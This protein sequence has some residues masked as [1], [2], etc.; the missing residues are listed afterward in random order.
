MTKDEKL[1]T[2]IEGVRFRYSPDASTLGNLIQEL[3]QGQEAV[4]VNGPWV[5]VRVGAQEGWIHADYL[6]EQVPALAFKVGVPNLTG[7]ALTQKVRAAIGDEFGGGKNGWELQCTEYV[8]YRVKTKLGVTIVW[9]VATGR[10]GG[11]W[12]AIFQTYGTYP[13]LA[14]PV[15]NCAMSFTAGISLNPSV[16]AIGHVAFVES[17]LPDGSVHVSEANWPRNGM[18]NERTITKADWQN[19]YK[20][21]FVHFI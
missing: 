18:Y 1:Y 3:P 8:A 2:K 11:K 12:A 9:P 5:K 6:S 7:D 10:N 17:V 15:A 16:N 19:K 4:F 20:A 14:N 13:V 21:Q